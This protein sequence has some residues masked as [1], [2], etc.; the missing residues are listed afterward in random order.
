MS[1]VHAATHPGTLGQYV[2][3]ERLGCG[4]QGEVWRAYDRAQGVEVALKILTAERAVSASAWA[5]L[6][7]VHALV[8]VLQHPGI[9]QVLPPQRL[10]GHVVLPMELADGGDL[11]E[12]RGRG[13][14]RIVPVLLQIAAALQDAHEHG[15]VHR[16]LKPTNVLFDRR[17]RVKLADFGIAAV[18]SERHAGSARSGAGEVSPFSASPE[19]LRGEPARPA[20]DIYGLGT[21]AYD[22]LAGHPPYFPHFDAAR[23]QSGPVPQLVP[24][25]PAPSRLIDLIL[26]MLAPRAADRPP[27]LQQVIEELEATL[28]V[29]SVLDPEEDLARPP[30][31][32]APVESPLDVEPEPSL[33]AK[34][35]PSLAAKPEPSFAA[36][37]RPPPSAKP[38]A[39][40]ADDGLSLTIDEFRP[41][42][43]LRASRHGDPPRPH[44]LPY[45]LVGLVCGAVLAVG[46][47]QGL[48]RQGWRGSPLHV[49]SAAILGARLGQP[50][51]SVRQGQS[52][53]AAPRSAAPAADWAAL[54]RLVAQRAGFNQRFS[55]LAAR[56]ASIWDAADFAAA[57]AQAADTS[58]AE[59]VGDIAATRR[60]WQRAERLLSR[61]EREAPRALA[62]QLA[63][64]ERALAVGHPGAAARAFALARRIE[65]ASRRA[66]AGERQVRLLAAV[67]PLM[68]SARRAERA[69]DYARAA[70]AIR[71]ALARDPT[72]A[73]ARAAL[74]HLNTV[75]ARTGYVRAVRAGAAAYA[76]GRLFQAQADFQQALVFRPD[77]IAANRGLAEVDAE[78]RDR[79]ALP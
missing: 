67:L 36:E 5:A 30:A 40:S 7:R 18:L 26:R 37:P 15:V 57:R 55:A 17:G 68:G 56:G 8:G 70:A 61:L 53:P 75:F 31:E 47:L 41:G 71:A 12:L 2:L 35:E 42:R 33:A 72:Y 24:L 16:D 62:T 60:H 78:L 63:A 11:T 9:L 29:T 73:P 50:V 45:L 28:N 22:L 66:A 20:D 19:Q 25:Q 43:G 3:S 10:E 64:G 27:S 59:A 38:D 54:G 32:R 69:H 1:Q 34:P 44:R 51:D 23:I 58:R 39:F 6:E 76:R 46:A 4:G 52:A 79:A 21:L 74:A 65:P 77:G 48:A 13:Y 14:L 49:L